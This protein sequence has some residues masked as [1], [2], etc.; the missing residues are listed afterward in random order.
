M[1]SRG[2]GRDEQDAVRKPGVMDEPIIALSPVEERGILEAVMSIDAGK[3]LAPSPKSN[4]ALISC[5]C[6]AS[7]PRHL[8]RRHVNLPR[9]QPRQKKIARLAEVGV[10][11]R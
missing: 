1:D 10:C 5:S 8:Q 11:H 7:S 2:S 6:P 4:R 3:G 9:N